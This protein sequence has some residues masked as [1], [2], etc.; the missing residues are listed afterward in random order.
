[1]Q[2]FEKRETTFFFDSRQ[3]DNDA[4]VRD[5]GEFLVHKNKNENEINK[6]IKGM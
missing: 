3:F 4:P 1:M 6:N 2:R 5:L